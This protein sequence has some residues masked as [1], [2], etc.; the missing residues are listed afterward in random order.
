VNLEAGID[1]LDETDHADVLNDRGVDS[2]VYGVA[3]EG[4]RGL[5]LA[6]LDQGVDR[7][8]DTNA[9]GVREPARSLQLIERE[10]RPLVAGIVS[11][12]AEVYRVCAV[13]DCGPH[14]IERARGRKKFRYFDRGHASI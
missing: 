1:L 6:R 12:R 5:Q 10:L 14:G 9:A 4:Q 11:L 3:K 8:L 13:G 2:S 7:Q